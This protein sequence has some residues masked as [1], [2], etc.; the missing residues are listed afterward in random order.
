[1]CAVL[2]IEIC[3]ITR[4]RIRQTSFFQGIDLTETWYDRCGHVYTIHSLLIFSVF[5][6]D[7]EKQIE[8]FSLLCFLFSLCL[9][10]G[11]WPRVSKMSLKNH[12]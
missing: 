10:I 11:L 8:V 6:Y 5:R 7:W 1:M 2:A 12:E 4:Q 9:V 3:D